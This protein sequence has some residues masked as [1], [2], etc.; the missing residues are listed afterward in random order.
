M[1][2]GIVTHSN[3]YVLILSLME[4]YLTKVNSILNTLA[5]HKRT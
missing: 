5:L 4:N 1:V 3:H 2:V